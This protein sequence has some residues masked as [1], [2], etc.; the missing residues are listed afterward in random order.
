MSSESKYLPDIEDYLES[1]D[2]NLPVSAA[3]LDYITSKIVL[4][5]GISEEI[6]EI[7][8][9]LFFQEIRNKLLKNDIIILK[10]LGRLLVSSPATTNN[11]KK[12][13]VKFEPT[14]SLVDKL[15]K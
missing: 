8:V 12:I 5:T 2:D 6:A 11:K 10:G 14:Q 4:K 3:G 1:I 15:N 7:L 9:K 13:F